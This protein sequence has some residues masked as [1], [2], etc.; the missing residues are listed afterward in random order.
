MALYTVEAAD[1]EPVTQLG[2]AVLAGRVQRDQVGLL[3][4]T[5]PSC[6]NRATA[7]VR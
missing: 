3:A 2:D 7:R 1:A 4:S 6:K 5:P